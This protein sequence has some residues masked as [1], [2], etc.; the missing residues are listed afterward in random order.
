MEE[1]KHISNNDNTIEIG[2]LAICLLL[3]NIYHC[4][5]Y[6]EACPLAFQHPSPL[7]LPNAIYP[8]VITHHTSQITSL[9]YPRFSRT[10]PVI[11][12]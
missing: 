4:Q 1:D 7:S 6:G 11:L 3:G 10:S 12:G 2:P 8:P 5:P 9:V